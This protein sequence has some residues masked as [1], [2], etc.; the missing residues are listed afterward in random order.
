MDIPDG[1]L[2]VGEILLSD[3]H[4]RTLGHAPG[5]DVPLGG[6]DLGEGAGQVDRPGPVRVRFVHGTPPSTAKSTLNA[7]GPRGTGEARELARQTVTEDAS[8]RAWRQ[9]EHGDVGRRQLRGRLTRTPVSILPPKS[10][11]SAASAAV[12]D[13][14]PPSATGQP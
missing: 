9:V 1:A 12:I 2:R 11:S 5:V 8:D 4:E 7:P 6:G 10:V 14:D 3:E 13:P